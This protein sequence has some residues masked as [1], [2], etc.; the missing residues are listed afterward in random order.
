MTVPRPQPIPEYVKKNFET[1]LRAFDDGTICL[2]SAVRK[3]DSAPVVL[4]CAM[5]YDEKDF[6]PTPFAVM[7]E[8][9]PYEL[10][11]DPTAYEPSV[12]T[13]VHQNEMGAD[14]H[15]APPEG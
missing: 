4:L 1:L 13:T 9:N 2:V 5:G 14:A 15:E 8:G 3:A 7:M 11:Y 10:F 6:Y 12:E